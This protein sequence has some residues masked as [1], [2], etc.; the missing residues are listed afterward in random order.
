MG[1]G[2]SVTSEIN[3]PYIYISYNADDKLNLY[4]EILRDE[5][6]NKNRNVV[7]SELTVNNLKKYS[8]S[9]ISLN[10][11]NIINNTSHFIACISKETLNSFYQ[12]IEID[13]A[14][15]SYKEVVYLMLDE[16][17]TPL[18]DNCVKGIVGHNKWFPF[19]KKKHVFDIIHYIIDLNL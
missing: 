19:Y 17:Y 10:L 4:I 16:V 2:S 15:N 11:N 8:Y 7:Y 1:S 14:L 12:A 13:T 6:V 9:E 18:N 3:K 5:L